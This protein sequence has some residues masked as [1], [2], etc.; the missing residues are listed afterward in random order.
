LISTFNKS[1]SLNWALQ[2]LFKMQHQK[3]TGLRDF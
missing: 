1:W 2:L 3:I